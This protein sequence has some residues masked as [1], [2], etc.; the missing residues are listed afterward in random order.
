MAIIS[1]RLI[2]ETNMNNELTRIIK[3]E[4]SKLLKENVEIARKRVARYCPKHEKCEDFK[5]ALQTALKR[6]AWK[7]SQKEG[8]DHDDSETTMLTEAEYNQLLNE[9][10]AEYSDVVGGSSEEGTSGLVQPLQ[11][12]DRLDPGEEEEDAAA[13]EKAAKASRAMALKQTTRVRGGEEDLV[14]HDD[15]DS[16][17]PEDIEPGKSTKG[18]RRM[19][20]V[21]STGSPP[22]SPGAR[23]MYSLQEMIKEVYQEVAKERS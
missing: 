8:L 6:Q 21:F 16:P 4:R 19:V 2:K 5:K 22:G 10:D 20:R 18:G 15:W 13:A 3:E 11:T 17:D 7:Q 23:P 9:V 12:L 1:L 14:Q